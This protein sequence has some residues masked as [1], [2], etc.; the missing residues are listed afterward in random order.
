LRQ[1]E[2]SEVERHRWEE[3]P[4]NLVWKEIERE[5]QWGGWG[6]RC[7]EGLEG[8]IERRMMMREEMEIEEGE[9]K[10]GE[11]DAGVEPA[12]RCE[13]LRRTWRRIGR[14]EVSGQRMKMR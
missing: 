3:R 7:E 8:K 10:E 6:L 11:S 5:H 4:Q 14:V 2:E 12:K 13:T 9:R 1:A